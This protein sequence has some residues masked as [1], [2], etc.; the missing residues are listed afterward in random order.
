MFT[1]TYVEIDGTTIHLTRHGADGPAVLLL[2]GAMS[3]GAAFES[4]MATLGHSY[5]LFAPDLRGMGRSD[6][7]DDLPATAWVDDVLGLLRHH[8]IDRV[9]VAGCSLGARVALRLACDHPDLISSLCLDAP[10][11]REEP[12]ATAYVER[13]FRD[14]LDPGFARQLEAWNGDDW[15]VARDAYLKYRQ[16]R[17][18]QEFYDVR[19]ALSGIICPVAVC[20]GDVDDPIHP[21]AHAVEVHT[22]TTGPSSLWVRPGTGFSLARFAPDEFAMF[23]QALIEG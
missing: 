11:V 9:H 21:I 13:V 7:A 15:E 17:Q 1:R 16:S 12:G 3:S 22:R 5:Q 23:F 4:I 10:V 8:D 6:Q 20:R 2:H 19:D 14:E 18:L